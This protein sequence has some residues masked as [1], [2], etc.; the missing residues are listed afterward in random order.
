[1]AAF[2]RADSQQ[3]RAQQGARR[4]AAGLCDLATA[5]LLAVFE[6]RFQHL[7]NAALR[8][9]LKALGRYVGDLADLP[10]HI[11]EPAEQDFA[12]VKYLQLFAVMR[13]PGPGCRVAAANQVID[14]VDGLG[15]VDSGFGGAA[16]TLVARL[17]FVLHGFR[18]LAGDY[19]ISRFQHRAHAQ[20]EQAVEINR[21]EGVLGAERRFLLQD[22]GAFVETV[23]RTEYGQSRL[24]FAFDD[25]PVDR[26]GAAIFRQQ[27]RVVLDGAVTR[28]GHEFLRRKLQHERHDAN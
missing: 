6:T 11:G 16:P 4:E 9:D 19:Q 12:R 18:V 23:R 5:Q 21:A 1:R 24:Y 15:P 22:D 14:V 3:S 2:L 7:D 26:A 28:N 8:G 17:R 13:R 20:R 27:R 10:R 25:R